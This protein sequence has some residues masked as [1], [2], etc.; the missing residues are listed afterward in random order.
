MGIIKKRKVLT[1]EEEIAL[2]GI[3]R[4]EKSTEDEKSRAR[5]TLVLRNMG[6]VVKEARRFAFN[7]SIPMEDLVQEGAQGLVRAIEKFDPSM[8]KKFSTYA[9][10]WV[11]RDVG[12]RV[13]TS[14]D[15]IHIPE[16]TSEA[17]RIAKAAIARF[18]AAAGRLPTRAEFEAVSGMSAEKAADA[19][20]A[21]QKTTSI[22]TPVGDDGGSELGDVIEDRNAEPPYARTERDE[23]LAMLAKALRSLPE[24]HRAVLAIRYGVLDRPMSQAGVAKVFGVSEADVAELAGRLGLAG[25]KPGSPRVQ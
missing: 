4:D 17:A 22:H 13:R 8:N 16:H 6:L 11:K 7:G 14:S 10:F 23:G 2:F 3:L 18:E 5:E 1:R 19:F 25:G 21:V 20:R 24:A 9:T 12:R 15:V